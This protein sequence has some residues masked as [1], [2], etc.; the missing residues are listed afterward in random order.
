MKFLA[1]VLA[2]ASISCCTA[3]PDLPHTPAL[4]RERRI[5]HAA[6]DGVLKC[7][8]GQSINAPDDE[9]CVDSDGL[10]WAV[11]AWNVCGFDGT[12]R[13]HAAQ[14]ILSTNCG[15]DEWPPCPIPVS[16]KWRTE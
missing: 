13:M 3:V 11:C 8:T 6:A 12:C 2:L 4:E 5:R 7:P 15:G 16:A 10:I 1:I 14:S 9:R